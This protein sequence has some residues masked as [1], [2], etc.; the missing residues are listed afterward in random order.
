MKQLYILAAVLSLP[1]FVSADLRPPVY[2][3]QLIQSD[4]VVV[5]RIE[6]DTINQ[7][8][9]HTDI[10]L[11]VSQTLRGVAP[12][13][14][15]DVRANLLVVVGGYYKRG[16]R[17]VDLRGGRKDYPKTRIVLVSGRME[18]WGPKLDLSKDAIWFL[19]K[20]KDERRCVLGRSEYVQPLKLKPYFLALVSA[21]PD[22]EVVK[23]LRHKDEDVT[24]RALEYLMERH[25][26]RHVAHI[27]PLL[28]DPSNKVQSAA[29]TAIAEVGDAAAVPLCRK[30]LG[31]KNPNVRSAACAFLCR[32]RDA[33]SIPAIRRALGDMPPPRAQWVAQNLWRMESRRA[34]PL[35]V[36]LLDERLPPGAAGDAAAYTVSKNAAESLKELTGVDFPT[37]AAEAAKLWARFKDFPDEIL[38]RKSILADIDNLTHADPD[39]RWGSYRRL[40]RLVN[41]HFGSY[42][43]F[44]GRKGEAARKASQEAWRK[45]AKANLARTRPDWVYAGFQATGIELP[46]PMNKEGIDTLVKVVTRYRNWGQPDATAR[47]WKVHGWPH[48]DFH[49]Y[50]ANLLLERCTGHKV[51]LSPYHNDLQRTWRRRGVLAGRWAAW[52][53]KNRDKVELK[54]WQE[55]PVSA[56]LL[57]KAPK[58]Q[59]PIKPLQLTIR[60]GKKAYGR[61]EM[62][63]VYV[64]LKNVCGRPIRIA[65][66][67]HGVRYQS[68]TG[69][70]ASGRSKHAGRAKKDFVTLDPGE[71]LEWPETR[72][73]FSGYTKPRTVE[74]FRYRLLYPFAGSQFGLRA[75]RGELVSNAVSYQLGN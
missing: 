50:N 73:A 13:E 63:V 20:S 33:A 42:N 6:L 72:A 65:W 10:K 24:L 60:M 8:D 41:Q 3:S 38:I 30:A 57:A 22:D 19:R 55:K 17:V 34:V 70:G 18:D 14:I 44:H 68:N 58:P 47:H 12:G 16:G 35:L 54:P 37:D 59:P 64:Q 26:P 61:G 49:V 53:V 51:G 48:A 46:R 36:E 67:P 43:A 28:D 4:L 31:H 1:C 71:T 62:P 27:A 75:W 74:G 7:A 2:D 45:W 15:M 40:G 69:S 66:R 25:L 32:F 11:I 5:A 29:A 39:V 21:K 9:R 56:E 23:V 52:W